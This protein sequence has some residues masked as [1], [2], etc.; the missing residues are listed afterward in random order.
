M[1]DTDISKTAVPTTISDYS[2]G[3]LKPDS[4]ADQKETYY[5]HTNFTKWFKHYKK[6]AKIKKA[7]DGYATWILGKGYEADPIYESQLDHINGWGED[8]F[9]SILWNMIVMKKVGEDAYAEIIR[10]SNTGILL[11]LKPLNTERMRNV[12]G[13]NGRIIRYEYRQA[14]KSIVKLDPN[15]VLHLCNNRVVDEIHGVSDVEAVEWIVEFQEEMMRDLRK[16]MHRNGVVRVIEVDTDDTTKMNAYKVQWKDA[17]E[18]GDVLLLPKGVAEAKDWHGNIDIPGIL[19]VIKYLDNL[20]YM[21]IGV[22][23]VILGG[24]EEFTEASSKIGYL[25]FEQIYLK[26][27][28]ELEADL[29]NQL[30]IKVKFNKPASLKNEMLGSEEKNTGQVGFQPNESEVNVERSE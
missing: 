15:K 5:D 12:T 8:T 6:I 24:S 16:I 28:T 10:D 13:P 22:P 4:P 7:I 30:A 9:Q 21:S 11:N 19:S 25:T 20:F 14:N 18:K 2:L 3:T 29:W 27:Q 17:I 26:E 23:R 1:A